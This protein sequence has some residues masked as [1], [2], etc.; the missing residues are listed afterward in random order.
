MDIKPVLGWG[1]PKEFIKILEK[2][3]SDYNN[4]GNEKD[5]AA[6]EKPLGKQPESNAQ[7][8]NKAS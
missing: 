1:L 3:M 7:G 4:T 6:A 5:V 8:P 2:A